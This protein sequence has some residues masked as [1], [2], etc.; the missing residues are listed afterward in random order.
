MASER[1]GGRRQAD[2]HHERPPDPQEAADRPLEDKAPPAAGSG[3]GHEPGGGEVPEDERDP[4]HGLSNPV[5]EP[6][7]T[8]DAD[9]YEPD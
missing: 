8:S 2:Y 5:G 6:D 9:P 3:P 1:K 7:P 4:H